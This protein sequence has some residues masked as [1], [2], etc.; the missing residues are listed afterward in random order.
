MHYPVCRVCLKNCGNLPGPDGYTVCDKCKDL[1]FTQEEKDR[2]IEGLF[3][4]AARGL[5]DKA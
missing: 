5:N 3:G 2:L 1:L 4:S